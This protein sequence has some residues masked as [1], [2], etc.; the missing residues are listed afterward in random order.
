MFISLLLS[1]NAQ[2]NSHSPLT[3]RRVSS[4]SK[5][6]YIILFFT[7]WLPIS[8]KKK[9]KITHM[10][11][12]LLSKGAHLTLFHETLEKIV[13]EKVKYCLNLLTSKNMIAIC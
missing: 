6:S 8:A 12:C 2:L 3:N 4:L 11:F 5:S 13:D 10:K 7:Y 9:K 1:D